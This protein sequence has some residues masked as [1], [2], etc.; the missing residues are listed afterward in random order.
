M[1]MAKPYWAEMEDAVAFAGIH[2]SINTI[3]TVKQQTVLRMP[4]MPIT[5]FLSVSRMIRS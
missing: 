2:A 1:S 4:F 3:I 5:P